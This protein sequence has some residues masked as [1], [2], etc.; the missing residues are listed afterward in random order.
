[1][2]GLWITAL[3]S[4]ATPVIHIL[5]NNEFSGLEMW[6]LHLKVNVL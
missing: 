4:R 3:L 1:M 2:D 6:K 5:F